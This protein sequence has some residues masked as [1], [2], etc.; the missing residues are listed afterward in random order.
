MFF[1]SS[2]AGVPVLEW[3]SSPDVFGYYLSWTVFGINS[4]CWTMYLFYIGISYLN[5]PNEW[6]QYSR[7]A[8]FPFF[9]IHQPVIIII[10][11][12]VVQWENN[13]LLKL[14]VVLIGS[15]V[16]SIGF[17]EVFIRRINP[18]RSL[19]GMKPLKT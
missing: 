12:Y 16:I 17:Y 3:L 4:F 7:E 14:V 11:F 9:L 1:F 5:S 10:A 15:F 8:S 2:A 19:L 18:V 6:L 13:S